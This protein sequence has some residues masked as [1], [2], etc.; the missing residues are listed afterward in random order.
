MVQIILKKAV[1]FVVSKIRALKMLD[2][3]E[4]FV[5]AVVTT[6]VSKK[7]NNIQQVQCS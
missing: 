6:M 2:F 1:E 4:F 3:I 5:K 7:F